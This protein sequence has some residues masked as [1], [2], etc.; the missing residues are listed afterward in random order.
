M[1]P[2]RPAQL[3]KAPVPPAAICR[4]NWLPCTSQPETWNTTFHRFSMGPMIHQDGSMV[5]IMGKWIFSF[6]FFNTLYMTF[7]TESQI[8]RNPTR[9]HYHYLILILLRYVS[10]SQTLHSM[11]QV[12]VNRSAVSYPTCAID[13]PSCC[14]PYQ[15][16]KYAYLQFLQ[17]WNSI[18]CSSPSSIF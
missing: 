17:P 1:L 3:L 6:G 13:N 14:V 2:S 15:V 18:P 8:I 7:H 11:F 16:A 12:R 10:I 5:F 9:N 4:S